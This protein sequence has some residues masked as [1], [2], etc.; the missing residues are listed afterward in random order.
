MN[1]SGYLGQVTVFSWMFINACCFVVVLGL[2]LVF[3]WLVV[4]HMYLYYTVF[5]KT[6]IF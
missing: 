4:M 6:G 1:L 2:D 3:S 5:Q